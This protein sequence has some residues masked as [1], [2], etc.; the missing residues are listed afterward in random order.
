MCKGFQ[1]G[2]LFFK[3][4]RKLEEGVLLTQLLAGNQLAGRANMDGESSTTMSMGRGSITVS[5]S[6][7]VF[8]T[9]VFSATVFSGRG[10]GCISVEHFG[11]NKKK[12]SKVF[13]SELGAYLF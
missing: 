8:S 9:G 3:V 10:C 5:S 4:Q 12:M 1:E 13:D 7:T 2:V 11:F 6:A